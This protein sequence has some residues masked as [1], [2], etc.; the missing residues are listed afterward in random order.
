[1]HECGFIDERS[2]DDQTM[3]RV[4]RMSEL[5]CDEARKIGPNIQYLGKL[6]SVKNTNGIVY[7]DT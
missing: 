7:F 6:L 5:G 2:I 3:S 1:M 4:R